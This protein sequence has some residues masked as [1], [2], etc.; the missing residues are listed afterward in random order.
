VFNLGQAVGLQTVVVS[1][2]LSVG[3]NILVGPGTTN[4]AFLDLKDFFFAQR[5]KLQFRT[6]IFNLF[7]HRQ[8]LQPVPD[9]PESPIGLENYSSKTLV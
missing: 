6:E 1:V 9:W 7:N 3:R 2:K 8:F 5:M 4:F